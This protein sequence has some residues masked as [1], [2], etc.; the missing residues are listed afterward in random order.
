VRERERK[1]E[2]ESERAR[3]TRHL[4][5]SHGWWK[6]V[7][8]DTKVYIITRSSHISKAIEIFTDIASV[9]SWFIGCVYIAANPVRYL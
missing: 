3:E 8:T 2:R 7:P 4:L 6:M 9:V 1:R 5:W